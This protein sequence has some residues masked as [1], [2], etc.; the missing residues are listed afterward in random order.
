MASWSRKEV[1]ACV[2]IWESIKLRQDGL[3]RSTLKLLLNFPGILFTR[4][5][6]ELMWRMIYISSSFSPCSCIVK[7]CDCYTEVG[8]RCIEF[9]LGHFMLC[10]DRGYQVSVTGKF[11]KV[12][13]GRQM[14]GIYYYWN[15]VFLTGCLLLVSSASL[16]FY[17]STLTFSGCSQRLK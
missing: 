3:W 7:A 2:G 1:Y 15:L 12:M 10:T 4:E 5:L 14:T 9:C 13:H 16:S 8:V 11:E 17:R 6:M